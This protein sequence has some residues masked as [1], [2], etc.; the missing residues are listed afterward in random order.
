MCKFPHHIELI[1]TEKE[2]IVP[3]P[4]EEGAG[5]KKM[6]Q[7]KLKKQNF[8]HKINKKEKSF[9][10]NSNINSSTNDNKKLG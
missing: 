1:L 4:E 2:Q 7:K 8:Q 9:S 3:K 6:P 10:S 5:R